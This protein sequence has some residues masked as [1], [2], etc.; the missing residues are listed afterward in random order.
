M[1]AYETEQEYTHELNERLRMETGW[2]DVSSGLAMVLWGY[3]VFFLGTLVG[4]GMVV[5]SA[6]GWLFGP[7]ARAGRLPPLSTIWMFY[8]GLGILSVIGTFGYLIVMTGQWK[9]QHGAPERNGARWLMFFCLVCLLAGPALNIASYIGGMQ[10]YP[11]L[12]RGA[13]SLRQMRFTT[14]GHY[15]QLASYA[16]SVLYSLFLLLFLRAVARCHNSPGHVMVVNLGLALVGGLVCLSGYLGFLSFRGAMPE[17]GILQICT[18]IGW[19]VT[20]VFYL[21]LIASVRRCILRSMERVCSP[22][23]M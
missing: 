20:F 7:G 22:L 17:D 8:I 16:A 5:Y 11:E 6:Y 9:C 4:V 2:K 14:T 1:L 21:F 15:M 19:L 3:L 12:S 13:G 18:A 10:R 23:D